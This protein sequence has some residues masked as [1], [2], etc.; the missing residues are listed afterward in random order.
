VQLVKIFG[1]RVKISPYFLALMV[2][3]AGLGVWPQAA[4][5]F[6]LVFLHEWVHILV[7]KG[8]GVEIESVELLP[9]GGVARFQGMFEADPVVESV[10]ALA[11]PAS[12][13]LLA[14]AGV[15][16]GRTG[17]LDPEIIDYFIKANLTVALF[18]LVPALPLDGGRVLR[19]WFNTRVG[20]RKATRRAALAG[21][22]TGIGLTLLGI[23][24][25]LMKY[26]DFTPALVGIFVFLAARQEEKDAQFVFLRYLNRKKEE[27]VKQGILRTHSLAVKPDFP[28]KEVI[29]HFLPQRFT[30]IHVVDEG[31]RVS[32]TYTET[33]VIRALF[34]K[35]IDYP[36]GQVNKLT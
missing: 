23:I 26:T 20:F 8:Y 22:G 25:L 17:W 30:I 11:G 33:Q 1:V 10:V 27:L 5:V 34:E 9:F 35:G 3:Y 6:I 29:R 14:L 15:V 7:A 28:V 32:S 19:A 18:N 12:N 24:S 2:M 16:V 36:V 21:K 4:A 13:L 31:F